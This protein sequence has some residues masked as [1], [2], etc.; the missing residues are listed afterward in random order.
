MG[1][2]YRRALRE[3]PESD[4]KGYRAGRCSAKAIRE[5]RNDALR[6]MEATRT[7]H[8]NTYDLA[9]CSHYPR[10]RV[11]LIDDLNWWLEQF[12]AKNA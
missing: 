2:I 12:G 10:S 5:R 11:V 7:L 1:A 4:V 3:N 6:S 9:H 8:A